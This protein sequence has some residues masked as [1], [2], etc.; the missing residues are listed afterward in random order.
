[1]ST[2]YEE[3]ADAQFVTIQAGQYWKAKED[4][5][6]MVKAGDVLLL[7]SVRDVDQTAHTVILRPH[8]RWYAENPRSDSEI[9]YLVQEFLSKFDPCPEYKAIRSAELALVQGRVEELQKQLAEASANPEVMKEHVDAGIVKW[10][11]D[12]KMLPEAALALPT[13][14][15]DAILDASL[16]VDK[17]DSMKLSM[18]KA[19]EIAVLQ[20][21]FIKEKVEEIS[22]T[23]QAMTP[24]YQEQ[25]AAALATTEDV[26]AHVEKLLTGVKSL[27]LYVGTDVYVEQV[28]KGKDAPN[29]LFDEPQ[30]LT[31]MQSKLYM[32]EELS[33]WADVGAEFDFHNTDLFFKALRKHDS[34]V[35]QIFPTDRCIV[36]MAVRRT[37]RDYGNG[38]ENAIL[39]EKNKSVFLLVRNGQNIHVVYSPIESHMKSPRLFPSAKDIDN[40]FRDHR[41]FGEDEGRK[42]TYNDVKYTDKLSEHEALAV[43]YKR[44]LILLCG[45]D[46]RLN[47]FGTFYNEPKDMK[48]IS[49]KF[50]QKHMNFVHDDEEASNGK[51]LPLENK[52][53]FKEWL[54]AKNG[55][56][57]SGSRVICMWKDV[58]N[59]DTAPGVVKYNWRRG[60]NREGRDEWVSQPLSSHDVSIAFRMGKEIFV[61]CPVKHSFYKRHEGEQE[62]EFDA[63]VNLSKFKEYK[64]GYIVLDAIK[65]DDLEWYIFDR[66]SRQG[67][68]DYI[69]LFKRAVEYLRREEEEE[70]ETRAML[71]KALEDG[72][73]ATDDEA[74]QTID[75]AVIAWRA[76]HRGEPL[77]KVTEPAELK[78]LFTQMWAISRNIVCN[79]VPAEMTNADWQQAET[80]AKKNGLEPLRLVQGGRA[81][82]LSLYCAPKKEE[83][84]N[85]LWPMAW[86]HKIVLLRRKDALKEY[87][88]SWRVLPDKNASE[89]ILH[90]W[91]GAAKWI[92]RVTPVAT[93]KEKENAFKLAMNYSQNFAL[94]NKP[95]A[96]LS[97]NWDKAYVIWHDMRE[98][99]Q[100]KK[101]GSVQNPSCFVVF[102]LMLSPEKN[103]LS[104]LALGMYDAAILM[105]KNAPD[106]F[107]Q[108][109][110][111]DEYSGRYRMSK[112]ALERITGV[113][114]DLRGELSIFKFP[115]ADQPNEFGLSDFSASTMEAN[116]DLAKLNTHIKNAMKEAKKYE[117]KK[118][119]WIPNLQED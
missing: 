9:R 3:T 59:S 24:F 85:R 88:R 116:V 16:T 25:A 49:M 44:F 73:I 60:A 46:H 68:A 71:R 30:S 64:T 19:H 109:K 76:A 98:Q 56:L 101:S 112:S 31:I 77:V 78:K 14:T 110:I 96:A 39:N 57:R 118:K 65:A 6:S 62:R 111:A 45:L 22:E 18:A 108:H 99:M 87:G 35:R 41:W 86:V 11:K 90:E 61:K 91:D 80:F 50:Q 2:Q 75:Q 40:I 70:K 93:F 21:G 105:W 115:V 106:E 53:S 92:G 33:A 119:F 69:R 20:A 82:N 1:M 38:Y 32:D 4:D 94:L 7:K 29:D 36:C 89:T 13:A 42:I 84:D 12:Q 8:P 15:P 100:A 104:Y 55:F 5:G 27:D 58:M 95:S 66:S 74:T 28:K 37:D 51:M 26:R 113:D 17:V 23:V 43:H 67:Y 107:R 97:E 103:A 72:K 81:Q 34:L 83:E 47:L 114:P 10:A 117:A 52:P 79:T 102:G 48:F 54:T 63:N